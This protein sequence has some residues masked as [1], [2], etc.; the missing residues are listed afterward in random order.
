MKRTFLLTIATLVLSGTA[1]AESQLEKAKEVHGGAEEISQVDL[2]MYSCMVASIGAT[3]GKC[4]LRF[5]KDG[6]EID[7]VASPE[8]AA[9]YA[10]AT[11]YANAPWDNLTILVSNGE[12]IKIEDSTGEK[13]STKIDFS[14]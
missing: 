9:I 5:E 14:R 10:V 7:L 1:F 8:V 2:R 11:K 3:Q 12:V 6:K 4:Q 13:I